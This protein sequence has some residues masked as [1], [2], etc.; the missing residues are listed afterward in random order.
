MW[1]LGADSGQGS[2]PSTPAPL[3]HLGGPQTSLTLPATLVAACSPPVA[4]RGGRVVGR[5]TSRSRCGSPGA[6]WV[7]P[8]EG[9]GARG[10]SEAP[11]S[12]GE[13]GG[14]CPFHLAPGAGPVL[15]PACPV[16]CLGLWTF[17]EKCGYPAMGNS[18]RTGSDSQSPKSTLTVP[19]FPGH[20][21]SAQA[22]VVSS[23]LNSSKAVGSWVSLSTSSTHLTD[24]PR[25]AAS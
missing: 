25:Q 8:G 15:C 17:L 13:G 24:P 3:P 16:W 2:F 23:N 21:G 4:S 18:G 5:R 20:G 12:S 1:A 11:G 7:E 22:S 19:M 6:L 9:S 10:G 14:P